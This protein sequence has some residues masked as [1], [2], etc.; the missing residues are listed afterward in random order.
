MKKN[1]LDLVFLFCCNV[2][3]GQVAAFSSFLQKFKEVK[4]MGLAVFGDTIISPNLNYSSFN[5]YLSELCPELCVPEKCLWQGGS[6]MK[7]R[8][9]G[10][11]AGLP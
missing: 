2:A 4:E 1:F 6:Y 5:S 3:M 11:S 10:S 7:G 8:Y 9:P